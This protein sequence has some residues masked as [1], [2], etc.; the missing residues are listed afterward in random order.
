MSIVLL[1]FFSNHLYAAHTTVVRG[2]TIKSVVRAYIEKNMSWPGGA[3]RIEFPDR[4]SDVSL[5]GERITYLVRSRRNKAFIGNCVF[6]V[7]FYRNGVFIREKTVRARLDV[8]MGVV[9]STRTLLR[10]IKIASNDVKLAK[11]WFDRIPL[12]IISNLDDVVGKR[13]RTSIKPNTEVTRNMVRNISVVK[14][15]KPVKIVFENDSMRITTIG[16]SEQDGALGDLVRIKNVSSKKTI[17]A[18]VMGS[19]LVRVEF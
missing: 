4:V 9:V 2:D 17:Y 5:T 16:L 3:V 10:N 18:R 13:L 1:L 8:S 19:S 11:K 7:S 15:G 12:N 14:R 6:S